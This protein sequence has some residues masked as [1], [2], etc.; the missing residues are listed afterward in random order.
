MSTLADVQ[1]FQPYPLVLATHRG[2]GGGTENSER[3]RGRL[4][5]D[6]C[7]SVLASPMQA[8]YPPPSTVVI[9]G[10]GAS[11]PYPTHT[12]TACPSRHSLL[13]RDRDEA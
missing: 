8:R 11:M 3:Q 12:S 13:L 10:F 4:L 5:A 9:Y 1:P 7:A 2:G 6:Q